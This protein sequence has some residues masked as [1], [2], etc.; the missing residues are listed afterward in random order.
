MNA[1][2]QPCTLAWYTGGN[3]C[4][5]A[6]SAPVSRRRL[7]HIDHSSDDFQPIAALLESTIAC[8]VSQVLMELP[9]AASCPIQ[10]LTSVVHSVQKVWEVPH[11][12]ICRI[13]SGNAAALDT[14]TGSKGMPST[15]RCLTSCRP[16]AT[17]PPAPPL[18]LLRAS[19]APLL[20]AIDIV[21]GLPA[22][23]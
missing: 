18:F 16:R 5:G 6:A 20:V 7:K 23:F 2:C 11:L 12:M 10:H 9:A 3:C 15:R 22:Q 14:I 1:A 8:E 19:V 17:R 4:A 13:S 21:H